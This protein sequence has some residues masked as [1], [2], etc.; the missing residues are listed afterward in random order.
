MKASFVNLRNK[1]SE[2]VCRAKDH[3]AFGLRADDEAS[4]DVAAHVRQLRKGRVD[5]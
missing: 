5:A 1:S 3:P 2:A 4:E